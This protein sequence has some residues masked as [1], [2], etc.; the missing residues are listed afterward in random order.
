MSPRAASGAQRLS[1]RT[2]FD[3]VSAASSARLLADI[4]GTNA[5]FAWQQK[6]GASIDDIVVLPCAQFAT[7]PDAIQ[8]YLD[9]IGRVAPPECAIAI[10]NPVVG[11][12][13][14]HDQSP[15]VVF[16]RRVAGAVRFP[17][18]AGAQ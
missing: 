5:R 9:T 3:T 13:V 10:A 7:L 8:R 4:G 11:D 16:D 2:P 14:K 12:M 15:L 1:S 18:S 6:T 17:H